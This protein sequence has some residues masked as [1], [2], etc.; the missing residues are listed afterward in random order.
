M[1]T[2]HTIIKDKTFEVIESAVNQMVDLIKPTY[3]PASNK[4]IIDKIPYRMVVDDGVQIARDFQLEDP[5]ENAVVKV[6]RETAVTTNDRAGDGTTSSLIMLQAI[7]REVGRKSSFNGRKIEIE[8]KKGL[9]D[10]R[11]YL[12]NEAT[13]IET[14]EDIKKVAL[15]SFDHE[16]IATMIS[17]IY[18]K[19]G[20]EGIITIDQ[21]PTMKTTVETTDGTRLASGYL[22]PYMVTNP[23]R[24]ET[25]IQK[26]HFLITDYRLTEADDV[27][28]IMNKMAKEGKNN[29]I[30]IAENIEQHALAT[31]VV[32]L[33]HVVNPETGKPGKF[34][35]IAVAAPKMDNQKQFLEDLA[36]IT[37]AK[38]FSQEKGERLE[39]AE[40]SHLGKANKVIVRRD[41]TV[42]VDPKGNKSVVGTA[43]SALREAIKNE[44]DKK[45]KTELQKRLAVFTNTLAVIKVGA[46]TANE[47]KA[48]KYKVEDA[49]HSVK[50]AFKSGVVCG[51][52]LAL[53]NIKTS[54][55]ILNEAL[56]YPA[57]QLRENMGLDG[58]LNIKPGEAL[59]VV[60]GKIGPFLDVGV[61]DPADVLLAG[62]ESAISIASLLLT[63]SGMIVE[64]AKEPK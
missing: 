59:N 47:Q 53:A 38:M 8:L 56:K 17:E 25:E 1:S 49:L 9:E 60:T 19:L 23:Q 20:K 61:V 32:N 31:M 50:S 48:L 63:S 18:H 55:P 28:G 43:V 41:E 12:K 64:S 13:Q 34:M 62:V 11:K 4:V 29:L 57:R 26:P 44:N 30:V 37:G 51:A 58:E 52:G 45:K 22:S 5:A 21:S 14:K 6:V 15:V 35:S 24:M 2:Q 54:S 33:P 7:I 39:T 40:V 36:L 10:V 46:A 27:L 16:E 42:I 3:G